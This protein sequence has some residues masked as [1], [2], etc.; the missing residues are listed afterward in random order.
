MTPR[1]IVTGA[2]GFL[3][4]WTARHLAADGAVVVGLGH[5][6]LAE[7]EAQTLGLAAFYTGDVD[8]AALER[9]AAL[10]GE[11]SLIVHCA[12][13]A[14]VGA[15]LAS[16]R[17]D[18]HRTA[19]SA[20]EV[21]EFARLRAPQVRVVMPSSAAVY[22]SVDVER[23]AEDAP[24][25]PMSPY[26]V[27]K[28][29]VE[30]LC[31]LHAATWG[32]PIAVVRLF[33]VY[34]EGLRKQLLWDACRKAERAEFRFFGDG[35]EQRDWLHAGDAA[36][37]L[38]LAGDKASPDCPVVNG[39][40][41]VGVSTRTVLGMLGA[42]FSPPLSP[43]FTGEVRPGDP[44]CLVADATRLACWGFIPEVGLA[45]GV[46]RYVDWFNTLPDVERR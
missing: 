11:P 43:E 1:V 10:H 40:T 36:R 23:L 22:G 6:A 30:E 14:S 28:R 34:G 7:S 3:G 33:S 35:E 20:V 44:K 5:G 42:R 26:G 4:R 15:S 37:L 41:G 17:E 24:L 13:G 21:L 32:T 38:A 25:R 31:R 45:E 27:H 19:A 9:T 16:P 2:A 39:G 18:F 46:A 29:L 12:G 8:L